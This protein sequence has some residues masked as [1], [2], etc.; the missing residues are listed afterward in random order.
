MFE[1]QIE[2]IVP[3]DW[4][5]ERSGKRL[6]ERTPLWREQCHPERR[7]AALQDR[8]ELVD[9]VAGILG[10]CRAAA[11]QVV[12]AAAARIERRARHREYL[13]SLFEGVAGRDQRP[14]FRRRLDYD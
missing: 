14:R 7:G 5:R 2:R 6:L 13:A 8:P 3:A 1:Q 9:H 10:Q 4:G 11:Q 12:T